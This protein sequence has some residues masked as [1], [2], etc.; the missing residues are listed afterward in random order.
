MIE[1]SME[2]ILDLIGKTLDDTTDAKDKFREFLLKDKWHPEHF[3]AWIEEC[4]RK[5]DRSHKVW[6]NAL[7]DVVVSIGSRLG[8]DVEFG[9]YSGSREEIPFDGMWRRPSGEAVLI[10]VKASGWP[11]TSVG[12]LGEYV[13]QY[14]E[15]TG[16][17]EASVFGLYVVGDSE[18]QHLIDQIKGGRFRNRLRLISFENLVDLW[19]LKNDLDEIGGEDA[20]AARVQTILLPIESVDVGNFVRLMREIA[21]LKR[22]EDE[23]EKPEEPLAPTEPEAV[24][25]EPWEKSELFTFF[26][27]NTHWQKAC[28]TVLALADEDQIPSNRL[29]RLAARVAEAHIPS[30]SGKTL[31]STAGVRAGFKMRRGNK[32]DFIVAKWGFDGTQWMNSYWIKPQYKEWIREWVSAQGLSIPPTTTDVQ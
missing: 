24:T 29:L 15:S 2:D 14:T 30:I 32:E 8:F 28:L 3:E 16:A 23:E 25:A 9:R 20:G 5:G 12:Q 27:R 19:C 18:V 21:E 26:R 17:D 7:Q 11:V 6:Y 1:P 10:E 31:K 4:T 13:E 22:A